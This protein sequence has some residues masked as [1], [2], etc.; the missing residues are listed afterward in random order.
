V[1]TAINGVPP[2]FS[3]LGMAALGTVGRSSSPKT[4]NIDPIGSIAVTIGRVTVRADL[5][6][7]NPRELTHAPTRPT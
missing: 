3:I 1:M 4:V 7:W 2:H 6:C 5:L